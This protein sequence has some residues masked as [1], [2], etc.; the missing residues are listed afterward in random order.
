[1]HWSRCCPNDLGCR[2]AHTVASIFVRASNE[3]CDAEAV[4]AVSQV[5]NAIAEASSANP[6]A[7]R[8]ALDSN[9]G[10]AV[11]LG[12]MHIRR[13]CTTQITT[14]TTTTVVRVPARD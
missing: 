5:A 4:H 11:T 14:T 8:V 1:M 2:S 13:I 9:G 10:D 6:L 3:S 7:L 12:S